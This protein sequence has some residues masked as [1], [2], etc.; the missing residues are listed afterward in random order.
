[1]RIKGDGEQR[2]VAAVT[3]LLI[4]AVA[5]SAA[6]LMLVQQ[7]A[8]LGQT[9]L[10]ASRAQAELYGRAGLDWARGV[11]ADDAKRAADF[12]ALNEAWAQP[13]VGLP[14][15]RAIVS[16]AIVDEQGKF[17]LNNLLKD[18]KSS[19][20]DMATFKRLLE[21]L[22]LSADLRDAVLDWIDKDSD[23]YGSGGAENP[24]YLA[25]GAPYR[26]ADQPMIQVEELY[27]IRGFDAKT[28][29]KLRPYVTALPSLQGHTTVNANTA[30]ATVLAALLPELAPADIANLIK[31]RE[32]KP[33]RSKDDITRA[34][35]NINPA[36]LGALDVKS[37]FFSVRVRVAQDDVQIGTEALVQ[38]DPAAG[39]AVVWR[40]PLY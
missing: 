13:M 29:A 39:V 27:R 1:M 11:L 35:K 31:A 4:V 34:A 7:S 15:D 12:D 18:G 23:L 9:S 10:V 37:S 19:G 8:M 36:A 2:G 40:R 17:N 25:L 24:Y 16:G 30:S 26:A 20:E 28:V 21:S 38:R 32:E 33:F 3:A 5:A 22:G 14:V 6:S